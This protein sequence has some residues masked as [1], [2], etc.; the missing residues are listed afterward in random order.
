MFVINMVVGFG[1]SVVLY[2][3]KCAQSNK[4]YQLFYVLLFDNGLTQL[5]L[6]N[7]YPC[8]NLLVECLYNLSTKGLYIIMFLSW[9]QIYC[10]KLF[11]KG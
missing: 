4:Y 1:G 11:K 9:R 6:K 2:Y 7:I 3:D 10:E 8:M 5:D